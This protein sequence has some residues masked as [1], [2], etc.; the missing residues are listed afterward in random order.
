MTTGRINQVITK[1]T[2]PSVR[3]APTV[4][5]QAKQNPQSGHYQFQAPRNWN[6]K[7]Q[8]YWCDWEW[9]WCKLLIKATV[10][11]NSFPPRQ[12]ARTSICI[13]VRLNTQNLNHFHESILIEYL[14]TK[15]PIPRWHPERPQG[16]SRHQQLQLRTQTQSSRVGNQ[17]TSNHSTVNI[18]KLETKLLPTPCLY[19]QSQQEQN[20]PKN[21]VFFG[22]YF[23]KMMHF[24][25]KNDDFLT[26]K[27]NSIWNT[28]VHAK[29]FEVGRRFR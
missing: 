25:I 20:T 27:L 26:L 3:E 13:E 5:W 23:E 21:V 12:S 16:L 22:V 28:M 9:I 18:G 6:F 17:S 15:N 24:G 8:A 11:Q 10:H 1:P 7:C 2:Q 14:T 4:G 29:K 19:H